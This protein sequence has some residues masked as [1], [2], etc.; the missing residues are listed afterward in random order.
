MF[1]PRRVAID[2]CNFTQYVKRFGEASKQVFQRDGNTVE[3]YESVS[4]SAAE[5][6]TQPSGRHWF[7]FVPV[8]A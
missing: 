4:G 7:V 5:K 2:A 8:G 3:R 1:K 6:V